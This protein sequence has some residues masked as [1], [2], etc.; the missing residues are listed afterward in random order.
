M[1]RVRIAGLLLLGAVTA[2][3]A[4]AAPAGQTSGYEARVVRC[5]SRDM[6]RVRCPADT[7]RGVELVRQLSDQEC[8]RNTD[9]GVDAGSI[10][11]SHGCRAE[12]RTGDVNI[13]LPTRRVVRCESKGR[14]ESCAVQLRGAPV[15]LLRQRSALPCR[16]GESW[17]YRRNE[18][19]VKRGCKGEFEVGAEDGSGF[20]DLPRELVCESKGKLRR[21]CGASISH[22]ATLVEQRSG[23]PCEEGVSWGWNR[24]GVW[25][26]KGCRAVFSVD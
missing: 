16:E 11:V 20:L 21:V 9:W 10:W 14:P 4:T 22:G 8:I 17:G 3:A 2:P 15:R 1:T 13:K 25:V 18:I 19:W 24:D 6:Q 7:S 12:F 23:M 5:E 26:D